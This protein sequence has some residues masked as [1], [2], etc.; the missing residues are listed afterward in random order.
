MRHDPRRTHFLAETAADARTMLAPQGRRQRLRIRRPQQAQETV[1]V[2][3]A[4]QTGTD[5]TPQLAASRF[6]QHRQSSRLGADSQ[7]VLVHRL[8]VQNAPVDHSMRLVGHPARQ[9]RFDR[10]PQRHPHV[11]R[12]ADRG[13]TQRHDPLH[14]RLMEIQRLVNGQHA[15]RLQPP[16][17]L[18]AAGLQPQ[19]LGQDIEVI[20]RITQGNIH[21]LD[22]WLAGQGLP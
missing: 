2:R 17:R 1:A 10:V 7:L 18:A 11:Y 6:E 5:K 12:I 20:Q 16:N 15:F 8:A 21:H 13:T 22:P 19:R 3:D 9:Q 14:H 4:I